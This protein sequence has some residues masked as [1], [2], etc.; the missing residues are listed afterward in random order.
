L[1]IAIFMWFWFLRLIA[2]QYWDIS[3][4]NMLC[5][6][7]KWHKQNSPN[8]RSPFRNILPFPSCADQRATMRRPWS[9]GVPLS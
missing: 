6:P 9:P 5:Q 2:C 4:Q 7:K 3:I 8:K 1:Q